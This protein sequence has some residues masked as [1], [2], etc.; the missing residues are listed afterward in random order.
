MSDKIID[1]IALIVAGLTSIVYGIKVWDDLSHQQYDSEGNAKTPR[2]KNSVLRN[3][4][5]SG[6][7][8]GLV[9]LLVCE[10]LLYYTELPF[11][12]SL[13]IGALC[14][15]TGADSFK[16]ILLRF[17][18]NKFNSTPPNKDNK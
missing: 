3:V 6:F 4:I 13:L 1:F 10:G 14:G 9:C 17:I 8:S 7:G 11:T 12:L 5:Y 18:E 15:F 2:D 16:D